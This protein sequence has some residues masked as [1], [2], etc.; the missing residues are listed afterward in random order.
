LRTKG[1][2][3]DTCGRLWE[4]DAEI[5]EQEGDGFRRHRRSAIGVQAQLATADPLLDTGL[6][7]MRTSAREAVSRLASI[8]PTT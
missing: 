1:L 6:L 3:F 7:S 5:G 4:C 8:Q 2:S